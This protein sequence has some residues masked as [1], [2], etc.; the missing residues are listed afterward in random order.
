VSDAP[1][2]APG[3]GRRRWSDLRLRLIS[4]LVL[5]PA[6]LA[7]LWFGQISWL[8]LLLAVA[9]GLALEWASLCGLARHGRASV[10]LLL[11]LLAAPICAAFGPVPL[12][13]ALLLPGCLLV[14]AVA[15]HGVGRP[16][17]AGAGVIYVGLASLAL[18]WLRRDGDAGVINVLFLLLVIWASDIGAYLA[19][20]WIGGPRLAPRISPG[21]TWSGAGGGLVAA[22][23]VGLATAALVGGATGQAGGQTVGHA[24]IAALLLACVGQ[25]GDLLESAIKR[26]VGVKDSGHL[27]PGHGGLLDRL[28]GILAAAPVAALLAWASGQGVVLWR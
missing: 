5:A 13:L 26:W 7:C 4:A 1:G 8:V 18:V 22:L 9:A 27:I 17:A 10:V 16:L 21:K 3:G 11:L 14:W 2:T 28:D 6:G 15:R 12:A 24:G 23:V 25:A 19:G 20:R